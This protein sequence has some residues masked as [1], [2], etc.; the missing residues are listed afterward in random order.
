M[1]GPQNCWESKISVDVRPTFLWT[2]RSRLEVYFSYFSKKKQFP[3]P[4]NEWKE[5][6]GRK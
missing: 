5:K 2:C 6:H 1:T 3:V 4:E